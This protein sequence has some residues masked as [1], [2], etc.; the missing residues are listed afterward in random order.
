MLVYY[1]RKGRREG[2]R[3]GGTWY[4][5]ARVLCHERTSLSQEGGHAGSVVWISHAG[6]LIRC[7]PE[8]LRP[9]TRDL[10]SVD[11]EINGPRNFSAL[12][13]QVGK[14]Q[15]YIDISQHEIENFI[16][17]EETEYAGPRFRLIGKKSTRRF[18]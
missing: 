10:S 2:A 17:D 3:Y 4:G 18:V 15:R 11:K 7:S 6:V 8:Q 1:F 13:E 14:S 9:V 5:P 16:P 12:L